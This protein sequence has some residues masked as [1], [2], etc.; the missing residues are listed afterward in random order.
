MRLLAADLVETT[1]TKVGSSFSATERSPA[2][3]TL[4]ADAMADMFCAYVARLA[5]S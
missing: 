3:I 1:L 2:E 4:Y 5:P